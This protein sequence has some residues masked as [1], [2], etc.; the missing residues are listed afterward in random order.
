MTVTAVNDNTPVITSNGGGATAAV[1]VA[2]NATA[3]TAVTA[4][5]ADLPGQTLTYSISG[6]ADAALFVINS[7][8][9]LLTF[10]AA[11][12]YEAP[13]DAGGDNVYDVTVQVSDGAFTDSQA[14]AVTVTAV[15]DIT[16]AITSDGGGATAAVNVAENATAVTTVTATDADLPAQTLTY[17]IVGGADAAKFAINGSTGVLSFVAAPDREAPTDAG[18]DNVYDVTVQV[19]DGSLTDTQAIAVTV[20]AVN[21][22][23]PVVTSNGAGATATVNVAE[24]ATA[25]TTVSATDADLP[26]QTLIYSISGGADAVLFAINSATGLLSFVSAPNYEAPTDAGGNNVYDVTVQVSDGSL[27]DTQAI[28]VTVT[29]VNDN[30]PVI[31]SDG[32]GAAATV[33]VA[34]N[35]TAVTTV[36]AT[37]ADLPGQTLTYA[38]SGGADAARFTINGSTGVLTFVTAPNYEAPT[39]AGADNVY[40]VTVQVSDGSLI[41]TQAIAVTVTN[42]NEAPVITSNGS[43]PSAG[44]GVVENQTAVTT[45]VS[46]DVDGAT[47]SYSIV[48][49]ADQSRFSINAATGVLS[50]VAAPDFEAPTDVGSD[51]IYDVTVQVS[52]GGLSDTQALAVTVTPVND[53][54]PTIT[55]NGGGTNANVNVAENSSAV[56]S[57]GATDADLPAQALTYS[58]SGGADA[59]RFAI[60]ASTGMLSFN[61]APDFEAPGDAGL[62]NVYDVTVRV[63]DGNGGSDT[64]AIAVSVINV[65]EAP[66]ITS[67]GGAATAL[68][69][70]EE[71]TRAVVRV[72]ATDPDRPAQALTYSITGG[73][74]AALFSIDPGTG[75]LSFMAAPN[76]EVPADAGADNVYELTLQASDGALAASQSIRVA[77]IDTNEAPIVVLPSVVTVD[78][79][80]P[81]GT[82]VAR[83]MVTDPDAGDLASFALVLDGAGRFT[84]DP[85]SGRILVAPGAL[86]DFES[87]ATFD[88]RVR[89][90]DAGGRSSEQSLRVRLGDVGESEPQADAATPTLASITPAAQPP[91]VPTAT[92]SADEL[93]G[94]ARPATAPPAQPGASG[95]VSSP[96]ERSERLISYI[97]GAERVATGSAQRAH[98]HPRDGAFGSFA[99]L[100]LNG[101]GLVDA[102]AL[103]DAANETPAGNSLDMAL[104]AGSAAHRMAP[105]DVDTTGASRD[106]HEHRAPAT[107]SEIVQDP[108][109]MGSVAFS[110]GFIW[111]LTRSGGLLMTMLM[112]IPAWRHIDLLPVLARTVDDHDDD[113]GAS[114]GEADSAG[115]T[116]DPDS[117]LR[118]DLAADRAVDGLFDRGRAAPHHP[119]PLP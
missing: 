44:V 2:E 24:N 55:S 72:I 90:T 31:T 5:D 20:T 18:G 117:E 40:D 81:A 6:G 69:S 17:S 54:A 67:N 22:N 9:G 13:A 118:S 23:A 107:L 96:T 106:T 105:I 45:V 98:A 76:F 119:H 114:G 19:S 94:T 93:T 88:L 53:N 110:A 84:I 47:P 21:D 99:S 71:N 73:A 61:A 38:I 104:R 52:D 39:D 68:V 56:T 78:E 97:G 42:V 112:G 77:V 48:G 108:V 74:D 26:G 49:G 14:I 11:P 10:A 3:V 111:W 60:D 46:T 33:N 87:Q 51:N 41:D 32:G 59:A 25:V 66:A 95:S 109:R 89:V 92:L 7:A 30:T 103:I 36:A 115:A 80:A 37:D 62:D 8:T 50:F 65:N 15:N 91:A 58:I 82:L 100:P 85:A 43:G 101:W 70:I 35:A 29:A 116:G 4:S 27:T 83:V 63:L 75:A 16:P 86:L 34:E 12:N 28:A 64:Q 1:N 113:E 102:V 79:N 57:V